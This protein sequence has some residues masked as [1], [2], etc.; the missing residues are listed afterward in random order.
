MEVNVHEEVLTGCWQSRGS[1]VSVCTV[2]VP[3]MLH[4]LDVLDCPIGMILNAK[5]SAQGRTALGSVPFCVF[6]RCDV[7]LGLLRRFHRVIGL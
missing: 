3:D 2:V 5:E 1:Q 4:D 6:I 7:W